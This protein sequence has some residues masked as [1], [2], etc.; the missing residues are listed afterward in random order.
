MKTEPFCCPRCG[1]KQ[2]MKHIWLMNNN[3]TWE[4]KHCGIILKPAESI[5]T[6]SVSW[7][8]LASTI[9]SLISLHIFQYSI[10]V[11]LGSGLFV[12]IIFLYAFFM[13]Y[14]K[15]LQLETA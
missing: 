15:T 5:S 7:G 14:Y 1:H 8:F 10:W 6:H 13:Y 2:P 12:S 3:F 11:S 4:C 9:P